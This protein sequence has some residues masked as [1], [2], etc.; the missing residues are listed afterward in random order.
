MVAIDLLPLTHSWPLIERG[1][2]FD[3]GTHFE[4]CGSMSLDLTAGQEA[5]SRQGIG[6]WDCDLSDSKLTWSPVVYDLFGLSPDKAVG[7]KKTLTLYRENSRA[8][9]EKLR[10]YAIKHSR[11]FTLDAEI[12][13]ANGG[14]RWIRLIAAPVCVD[15]RATRLRGFKLDVS[16]EYR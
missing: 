1:R 16:H 13:P 15:G 4:W 9:M 5:L 2:R 14:Q 7:R 10:D 8:K 3:I 12:V 11:G 6:T